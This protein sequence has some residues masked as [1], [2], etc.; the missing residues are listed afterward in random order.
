MP[1]TLFLCRMK[2]ITGQWLDKHATFRHESFNR[3][4]ND[5]SFP[6]P[7]ALSGTAGLEEMVAFV[8]MNIALGIVNASDVKHFWS[9][10]PNPIL[11]HPWFPSVMSRDRFLQIIFLG[12]CLFNYR[13][14]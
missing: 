1:R 10:D 4:G 3:A 7:A 6:V 12:G 9:T 13:K 2:S 14:Q 5:R 8:A 11:S